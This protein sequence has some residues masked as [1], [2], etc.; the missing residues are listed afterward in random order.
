MTKRKRS[1]R[2]T[3]HQAS[4]VE[5][6]KFK[7]NRNARNER[8][9]LS[10]VTRKLGGT[11]PITVKITPTTNSFD[12]L[13]D[14]SNEIIISRQP[15]KVRIPPITV[16]DINHE[17][18]VEAMAILK[19]TDYSLAP[20][21][22]GYQIICK[23]VSD[24]KAV[25]ADLEN[26]KRQFYS[27]QL[28]SEKFYRVV[29]LGLVKMEISELE[30][31]LKEKGV[32]PMLIKPI[33][34]KAPRYEGHCNYT[35]CFEKNTVKL[36]TLREITELNRYRVRWEPFRKIHAGPTQCNICMR[37]GHGANLCRMPP[38]CQYCAGDHISAKCKPYNELM[39]KAESS[40]TQDKDSSTNSTVEVEM[41]SFC[42]N[43]RVNGHFATSDLCPRRRKYFETHS[44]NR[45]LANRRQ[46]NFRNLDST[47]N[48][49]HQPKP[50]TSFVPAMSYAAVVGSKPSPQVPRRQEA[51]NDNEELTERSD[52]FSLDEVLSFTCEI[53]EKL[54]DLKTASRSE[55]A[56]VILQ[57]SLKYVYNGQK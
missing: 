3:D 7:I 38:R 36:E 26:G 4:S 43:C 55:M 1:T 30:T 12:V 5:Q 48:I 17:K 24:F 40:A 27:H 35:L 23:T 8:G 56:K 49:E 19:I 15:T 31:L 45:G 28:P 20:L 34:P 14:N 11:I 51:I 39:K 29:L 37:P 16:F 54:K 33:K 46:V 44:K 41:P 18:I 13:T 53:F 52:P 47:A 50:S 21:R 57:L 9:H 42:C 2:L 25:F 10:V 22:R 6:K 32:S